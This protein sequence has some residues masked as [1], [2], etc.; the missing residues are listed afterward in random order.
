[1]RDIDFEVISTTENSIKFQKTRFWKE[2]SVK[3]VVTLQC[4]P[5]NS[6]R[7]NCNV[8]LVFLERSCHGI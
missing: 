1:V 7:R 4:L 6:S 8:P 3:N 5:F 2:E